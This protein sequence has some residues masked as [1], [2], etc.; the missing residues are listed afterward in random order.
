MPM[1]THA[2]KSKLHHT[3]FIETFR[4]ASRQGR[5]ALLTH[6]WFVSCNL[7]SGSP[8]TGAVQTKTIVVGGL[9][10]VR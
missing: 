10:A 9:A 2:E 6:G 3:Q 5:D 7:L 4:N 8:R 1:P